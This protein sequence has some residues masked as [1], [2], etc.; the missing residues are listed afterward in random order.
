MSLSLKQLCI[1]EICEQ[2]THL[3]VFVAFSPLPWCLTEEI[4][5]N[6]GKYKWRQLMR[7]A[8]SL[9]EIDFDIL[10]DFE[11]K[12]NIESELQNALLGLSTYDSF[13]D[14]D[15]YCAWSQF[16]KIRKYNLILCGPCFRVFKEVLKDK[17]ARFSYKSIHFHDVYFPHQLPQKYQQK[18]SWCHN[19]FNEIIFE[20]KDRYECIEEI[21]SGQRKVKFFHYPM[22]SSSSSSS[23][24]DDN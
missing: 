6:F 17:R 10:Q 13:L 1:K 7:E 15:Y 24:E 22:Q 23:S 4:M 21:H 3:S 20:L 18:S 2:V 11:Y 16:Y 19:H 9:M 8:Q 14:Y 5:K 12:L